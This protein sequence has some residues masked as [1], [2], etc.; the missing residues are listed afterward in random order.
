MN[1]TP[2]T[3]NASLSNLC[4]DS[5]PTMAQHERIVRLDMQH[6]LLGIVQSKF[7]GAESNHSAVA[8]ALD[9][10]LFRAAPSFQDYSDLATLEERIRVVV[11]KKLQQK[12]HT[13]LKR[14]RAGAPTTNTTKKQCSQQA[15]KKTIRKQ[16]LQ[17]VLKEDYE[18]AQDLV[19]DI[20]LAKNRKV[21]TFKCFGG[22]CVRQSPSFQDSSFPKEIKALFFGTALV[23][24]FD[25][26][27]VDKLSSLNW[28]HL[29]QVA[30]SNLDTYRAS[31]HCPTASSTPP[32]F[33]A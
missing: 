14:S 21:A 9:M 32:L 25:K 17:Q 8:K 26:A 10:M 4:I 7:P 24:A 33:S 1:A 11:T 19:R 22:V 23:D 6:R 31:P 13:F 3:L 18:T 12:Q 29:I 20:K 27:P 2:I 28:K 30:Q 15:M 5:G 16:I